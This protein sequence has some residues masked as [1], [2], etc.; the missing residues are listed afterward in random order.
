[1]NRQNIFNNNIRNNLS[2]PVKNNATKHQI[3]T[4]PKLNLRLQ[5]IVTENV[6]Q[7]IKTKQQN[8]NNNRSQKRF[9]NLSCTQN[10]KFKVFLFNV[11]AEKRNYQILQ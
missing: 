11:T 9:Q 6:H 1:M 3:T 7:F 2:V 5:S 4:S 10:I 8:N